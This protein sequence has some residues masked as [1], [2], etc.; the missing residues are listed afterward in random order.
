MSHV[1]HAPHKK[2]INSSLKKTFL[3]ITTQYF[4]FQFSNHD[5][6]NGR[7]FLEKKVQKTCKPIDIN[8]V[9]CCFCLTFSKQSMM[10]RMQS[11]FYSKQYLKEGMGS[12]QHQE[13]QQ[14]VKY[15]IWTL[16]S[17]MLFKQVEYV[18]GIYLFLQNSNLGWNGSTW[19]QEPRNPL[20]HFWVAISAK[21][22][23]CFNR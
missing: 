17:L 6:K 22:K 23:A 16:Q 5:F 7:V 9:S 14:L 3:V 19:I 12:Q 2:T 20:H 15:F 1:L 18:N 21:I 11:K 8:F 10:V 4:P 13:Q